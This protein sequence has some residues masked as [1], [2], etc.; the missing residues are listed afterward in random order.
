MKE[1]KRKTA[2]DP[3]ASEYSS[4]DG[5]CRGGRKRRS[6]HSNHILTQPHVNLSSIQKKARKEL[7]AKTKMQVH[8]LTGIGKNPFPLKLAMEDKPPTPVPK[9]GCMRIA[10][11]E[12][13]NNPVNKAVIDQAALLV[14]QAETVSSYIID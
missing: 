4:D 8:E 11:G 10:F 5:R 3:K 9:E 14:Y 1:L 13:V 6:T 12:P 7:K 2:K